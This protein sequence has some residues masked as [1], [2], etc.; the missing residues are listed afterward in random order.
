MQQGAPWKRRSIQVY[1]NPTHLMRPPRDTDGRDPV[2]TLKQPWGREDPLRYIFT[3]TSSST[4]QRRK[5]ESSSSF[6]S[7]LFGKQDGLLLG[8]LWITTSF[9]LWWYISYWKRGCIS[10][11]LIRLLWQQPSLPILINLTT[12][13]S[14]HQGALPRLRTNDF[15]ST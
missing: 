12:A 3:F 8:N 6:Q 11:S 7:S 13:L 9:S 10:P 1:L 4:F 2:L 5:R 15:G 14:H